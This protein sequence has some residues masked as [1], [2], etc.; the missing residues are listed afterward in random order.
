M[1]KNTRAGTFQQEHL[2]LSTLSAIALL[3]SPGF[4]LAG[5]S[6]SLHRGCT[7]SI[8]AGVRISRPQLSQLIQLPQSSS[9]DWVW[10]I[11]SDR[12]S[13][14]V[15][16]HRIYCQMTSISTPEGQVLQR[17]AVPMSWDPEHWIVILTHKNQF[18]GIDF[19]FNHGYPQ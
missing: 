12:P 14:Q 6:Q 8:N 11:L 5:A 9:M 16:E 3:L 18:V 2:V 13:G 7:G 4:T 19:S 17:L 10:H 15:L 1:P